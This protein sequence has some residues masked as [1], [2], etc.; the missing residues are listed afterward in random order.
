[1]GNTKQDRIAFGSTAA[2]AVYS[3]LS[4]A[5]PEYKI[6]LFTEF[7]E[8]WS[9]RADQEFGDIFIDVPIGTIRLDVKRGKKNGDVFISMDS[10]NNFLGDGYILSPYDCSIAEAYY[11]HARS[12]KKYVERVINNGGTLMR[13]SSSNA[14][15]FYFNPRKLYS[16]RK[17]DSWASFVQEHGRNMN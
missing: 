12:I 3:Y 5:L 11:V 4:Q 15:G 2:E 14:Y 1:M 8:G 7:V 17:L 16:A 6:I 13:A 10:I 9:P